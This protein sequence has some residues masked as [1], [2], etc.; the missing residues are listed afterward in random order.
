M[1]FLEIMIAMLIL[2][3]AI[4]PVL[5]LL[6]TSTNDADLANSYIFAQNTAANVLNAALD[7]LPFDTLQ[8]STSKIADLDGGNP[9]KNVARLV[10]TSSVNIG[11]FLGLCGNKGVDSYARGEL[12]DDRGTLY[13]M[14]L[15][16]F[17]IV[18]KDQIDLENELSFS[19]LPRPSTENT[20]SPDGKSWW[21]TNDRFVA[22]EVPKLPYDIPL[23]TATKNARLL[24]VPPGVNGDYCIMKKLVFKIRWKGPK[25][26]E[27]NIEFVTAKANLSKEMAK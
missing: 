26:T 8:V 21:Y 1:S 16:V 6:W 20:I 5:G 24:G 13:K 14:K 18:G 27:R 2:G 15:Y 12:K 9:E 25:G 23:A 22:R 4:M 10:A 17:P 11:A 3:F 7:T 19:Y